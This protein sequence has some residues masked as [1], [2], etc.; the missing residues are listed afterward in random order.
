MKAVSGSVPFTAVREKAGNLS[1]TV[2]IGCSFFLT[3]ACIASNMALH[4]LSI[5]QIISKSK[6]DKFDDAASQPATAP[7]P[8]GLGRAQAFRPRRRGLRGDAI[9]LERRP[10]GARGPAR[11]QP[12]R[13][14]PPPC[15]A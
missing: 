2:S 8:L 5:K 14:Q 10:P 13:A 1:P 3:K 11:R 4:G 9:D 12:G 7:L 15:P 6:I